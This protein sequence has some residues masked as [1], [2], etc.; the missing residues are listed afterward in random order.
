MKQKVGFFLTVIIYAGL[1]SFTRAATV[2]VEM[3]NFAFVP[4]N[5]TI[6]VGDT[7]MWM[8]NDAIGHTSTSGQSGIPDG[9]WDSGLIN[10]GGS[11]S[12]TFN[13]VGNFPY[14]CTPHSFMTGT[15]MVEGTVTP[16]TVSI[17]TPTNNAAFASPG[18]IVIEASASSASSAISKVDFFD[19]GV[20][21][22]QDAIAPYS[23]TTNFAAG[24]HSLTATATDASG[25]TATST[26]VSITVGGGGTKITDP[27]PTKIAKGEV[28]IE[29]QTI[30]DGLV[31]PLGLAVPD[32]NSGRLFVYDQVGLIY[33]VTNSAKMETPLLDV[34]SR[35][36]SLNQQYDERGLL[37]V[38]THPH[39]AQK[40]FVYTYTSEPNGPMA[41]FMVMYEDAKTNNHQ[42][43]IA[44]WRLDPANPN[45]LDPASRR[46]LMRIDKPQSN[47]NGGTMR[48]GPDGFLYFTVGDGGAADDQ[49]DGHVPGGN[50]QDKTR[51]LG[52]VVRIDVDTRNSAN[53]QYG[54]PSDNPFINEAGAVRE[55]YAYGVRNPYSFTF[56]RQTGDLLLGDVGQND[57]EE[58]DKI[59]KGGNFGWPIKEGTFYFDPNGTNAGFVTTAP[60][61]DVPSDLIE[62]FAQFDHDEGKAIIG[63][64]A[65]RGAQLSQL[66]GKYVF[67]DW[68]KFDAAA[69]RLFYIDGGAIKEFKIGA[70]DRSLGL[71]LKGFGEDATGELYVFASP[72]LGPSGT[73]GKMLKIVPGG[74]KIADPIPTKIAKGN[75]TVEL[76]PVLGGLVS[77]L[78]LSIPDDNSGRMLLY[79]QT[80]LIHVV[81]N[82]AKVEEPFLDVRS[83]LVALNPQYD[84]RG[85]LGV[86]THPNFAQHPLVYTYTSEPNGAVADFQITYG[87]GKTNNHQSVIAEWRVD[88]ANPNR[89]DPAS[90]RELMRIDKPQSN[91][92]GGTMR[93]G[94]DGFLYFTV[95]DGGAADD[96]G[97]G[98]VPGGNAQDKT[99]I[100]GKVVRID[101]D[102]R[103]SANGQYGIPS[104]NPFVNEAGAVKEI[105]SY[106][107]RNPYSFTFDRQTGELLLGDVGQNDVEEADK[108]IKGGNFGWPIKEGTFYFDPNG[109]NAGFVTTA[110]VR[111]VP[112]DLIEPFAQFDHDEGKAIIGGYAYRGAELNQL[113]GKYIFGDW[114]KFDAAAGRLFYMD[115]AEIKELK[116][117]ANDRSFGIWLKGFGEDSAGELYVFGSTNLGPSGVSGQMLKIVPTAATPVFK[118]GQVSRAGNK[119]TITWTGGAPPFTIE[120]KTKLFDPTWTTLNTISE[121]SVEVPLDAESGFIRISGQNS[122]P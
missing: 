42:S 61:R 79:D 85:L 43:V 89:L 23:F 6:A 9:K 70:D 38:A 101:V 73:S 95:G 88:L 103:N 54:I 26:A 20:L 111:D 17:T 76:Q 46:E 68:G 80:G 57:V 77:P 114:G 12:R 34:R 100:L 119:L 35:L 118:I 39:F 112:I 7:V 64:Y 22:G 117:G 107:V 32:D 52:K 45:R 83:R 16:P 115:G 30:L 82:G 2:M 4:A 98:H 62:P 48:F 27:I 51:I 78:G 29:L 1:L 33:V 36:V 92:N 3:S 75:V 72:D 31:S 11:F 41:D 106:G 40:P 110:P 18:E 47:H 56:D 69:G 91:H 86:A 53:G 71:W 28:T 99:R 108:I 10:V 59:T 87:D 81:T 94:P 113:A 90:R 97:D 63:G 21:L 49:G 60:I 104:D 37:G 66:A 44:E 93:F 105:Y 5:V 19:N 84:E 13:T 120:L 96:Q 24:S 55:I 102:T 116:I 8:N 15:I 50:A 14:Y 122:P 25:A 65:Y 67:G 121:R 109:T 74:T 58:A